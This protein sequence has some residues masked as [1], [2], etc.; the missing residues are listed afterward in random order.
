M[1]VKVADPGEKADPGALVVIC[2][3]WWSFLLELELER[4]KR[5]PGS[6]TWAPVVIR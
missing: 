1:A 4:E 6:G 3:S 5:R 2:L